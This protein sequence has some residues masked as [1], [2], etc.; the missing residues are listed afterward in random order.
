MHRPLYGLK[1]LVI[2]CCPL[3]TRQRPDGSLLKCCYQFPHALPRSGL[4]ELGVYFTLMQPSPSDIPILPVVVLT[5]LFILIVRH[6]RFAT[7]YFTLPSP[8]LVTVNVVVVPLNFPVAA[9]TGVAKM[10]ARPRVARND[11]ITNLNFCR[12][13]R[14]GAL[15]Y[16]LIL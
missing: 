13:T 10:A 2:S 6:G 15:R 5:T 4:P 9:A 16:R 11:F 8:C 14:Y 1:I 12:V 7:Q 3:E